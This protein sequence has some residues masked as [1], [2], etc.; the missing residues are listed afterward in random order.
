MPIQQDDQLFLIF[1]AARPYIPKNTFTYS[2]LI[3]TLRAVLI[4]NGITIF[5]G[6]IWHG[7]FEAQEMFRFFVVLSTVLSSRVLLMLRG[8]SITKGTP[9]TSNGIFD[10]SLVNLPGVP[11]PRQVRKLSSLSGY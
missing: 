1:Q 8:G 11:T 7:S 6:L 10:L 2:F 9:L 5:G 4:L 3:T